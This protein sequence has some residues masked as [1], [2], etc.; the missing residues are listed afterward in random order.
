MTSLGKYYAE[1]RFVIKLLKSPDQRKHV[2]KWT[3]TTREDLFLKQKI[4]WLTFDAIDFLNTIPLKS[5]KVFEWGSG[6]STL[7]WLKKGAYVVSVEHDPQWYEKMRP[8]L[9]KIGKIDYK[10]IEP[11]ESSR[12]KPNIA[13]PSDP[14]HYLSS[15]SNKHSFYKY[16]SVIEQYE[17]DYFDV[18]LIDGRARPSCIKHAVSKIKRG[19]ILILDNSDRDYYLAKTSQ[20]LSEFQKITY[21]GAV[22]L[23]PLFSETSVYIKRG[24]HNF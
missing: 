20:Y 21:K 10:L 1:L 2:L 7:F 24:N 13:D 11:E 4:P 8:T 23:T 18:I 19:G 5:K 12:I 22:P 14:D 9:L 3:R 16:A 15:N 17:N 6:G